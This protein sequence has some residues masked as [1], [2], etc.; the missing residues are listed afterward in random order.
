MI[1]N[2]RIWIIEQTVTLKNSNINNKCEMSSILNSTPSLLLSSNK[3]RVEKLLYHYSL[4]V[5]SSSSCLDCWSFCASSIVSFFH[6]GLSTLTGTQH[7]SHGEASSWCW[8]N[9]SCG[10][11]Y[12]GKC[13]RKLYEKL[14]KNCNSL[15]RPRGQGLE[16]THHLLLL[17]LL[18]IMDFPPLL[19]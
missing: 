7:V 8:P 4:F 6:N 16:V 17:S 3:A 2:V 5:W 12:Q 9:C 13:Q 14:V 1:H 15:E 19:E 18:Q 11:P 10:C